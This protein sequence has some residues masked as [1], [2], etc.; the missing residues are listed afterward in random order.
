MKKNKLFITSIF[1]IIMNFC[2]TVCAMSISPSN[3]NFVAPIEN[4]LSMYKILIFSLAIILVICAFRKYFK[5]KKQ[6]YNEETIFERFDKFDWLTV[7]LLILMISS[8]FIALAIGEPNEHV[9]AMIDDDISYDTGKS[10]PFTYDQIFIFIQ[11]LAY[12]WNFI[13]FSNINKNSRD[14]ELEKLRLNAMGE[15]NIIWT[16]LITGMVVLLNMPVASKPIIYIYPETETSVQVS[17][18]HPE[19]LSCVYPEYDAEDGWEVIAKPNGDLIDTK[20]GRNLYCLYWE[21]NQKQEYKFNDGFVVAGKDSAKF[22][23]EKL[24]ILGLNER[25]ANE[26]I[27]YWLPKLEANKYNLIRFE[28]TEEIEEYMPLNIEP[29]PDSLIRIMMD[30]KGLNRPLEI[31]EQK[32]ETVVR[33]GYTVVEWGGSEF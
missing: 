23:E 24:A 5:K 27:I 17:V 30:F 2:S 29:K 14:Y 16:F 6:L 11:L 13:L 8:P 10:A 7:F 33:E 22:L 3:S 4:A 15:S 12:V 19:K 26:F 20:T 32:L 9:C 31:E 18:G 21:G 25:E 1:I 28:T